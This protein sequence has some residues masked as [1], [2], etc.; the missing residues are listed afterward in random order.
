MI[1]TSKKII[2]KILNSFEAIFHFTNF[3]FRD[4][5][6]LDDVEV[7]FFFPYYQTGGAER[8]H[9]NIVKCLSHKNA[10]ILFT[11]NSS[12]SNFYHDFDQYSKLIEINKILTKRIS[13]INKILKKI[14]LRSLNTNKNLTLVFGSNTNYFYELL[15]NINSKI[16]KIDLIHAI[17]GENKI[18]T[19]LYM[20]C[21]CYL[22]TRIAINK[23]AKFDLLGYYRLNGID[24]KYNK[25]IHII[26]NGIQMSGEHFIE[27]N[28]TK[29]KIGFVG[30]WSLEKRPELFLE[31]AKVIKSTKSSI[32]FEMAGI[33][34][35]SNILKI[36][37]AGVSFLGEIT[38]YRTL[39]EI[40][41]NL[42]FILVTSYREGFPVVIMEAM[43][44]GVIPI[45][46][47]VG[48]INEH[49]IDGVNG[50]LI[51]NGNED[52]IIADFIKAI[53]TLMN[54]KEQM[55]LIS[56]NAFTYAHSNFQIEKFNESYKK[57]LLND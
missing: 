17:S 41:R 31:I 14:I 27:K 21:S 48:G 2:R 39:L 57:T 37:D 6:K 25:N 24:E 11:N 52:K 1:N 10:C 29:I 45:A 50:L 32:E 55:L 30:R 42:T 20:A 12:T 46:T 44:Q 36:N 43:S 34:M 23:K 4:I 28:N 16:K 56:K 49:I 7:V 5:K 3:L 54:D 53:N 9:L 51:D 18:I 22:N 40:Y 38:D 15:P 35:K 19:D 8:V 13:I 33:G 26:G 47:N